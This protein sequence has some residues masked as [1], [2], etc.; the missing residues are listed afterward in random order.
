MAPRFSV[1]GARSLQIGS[2]LTGWAEGG[3]GYVCGPSAGFVLPNGARR[4]PDASRTA[5]DRVAALDPVSQEGF[6]HLC[7]D[8]VVELR[9]ASD[10]IRTLRAKM[11]EYMANGA[12]LGWLIDAEARTV[13]IYR[14]RQ[15]VELLANPAKGQGK[16]CSRAQ[17]E[18]PSPDNMWARSTIQVEPREE[19]H[20]DTDRNVNQK[21]G[22]HLVRIDVGA[23][24][25]P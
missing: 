22:T 11:D 23:E 3:L 13:S 7:P 16:N 8:F 1:D 9:C 18:V 24:I 2:G 25:V 21:I 20:D 15:E 14:P 6:W 19:P 4:S 10:R 5:K 17:C 12:Q